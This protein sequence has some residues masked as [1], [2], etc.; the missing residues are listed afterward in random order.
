MLGVPAVAGEYEAYC[1]VLGISI[2]AKILANVYSVALVTINGRNN[3]EKERLYAMGYLHKVMRKQECMPPSRLACAMIMVSIF[4]LLFPLPHVLELFVRRFPN[5]VP[6]R[7]SLL[8]LRLHP[9]L[10]FRL[11]SFQPIDQTADAQTPNRC[12]NGSGA[13]GK[14]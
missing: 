8:P 7:H 14:R 10:H 6:L 13:G 11:V 12:R 1:I 9:G 5:E 2:D 3:N 4:L